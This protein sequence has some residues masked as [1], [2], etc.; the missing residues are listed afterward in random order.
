M[1][2]ATYSPTTSYFDCTYAPG[3]STEAADGQSDQV[4][5]QPTIYAPLGVPVTAVDQIVVPG[6]GTFEVDGTP[7]VWPAN[8]FSN[9]TPPRPVVIRLKAVAGAA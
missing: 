9:R 2:V 1:G 8:P 7:E 3:A 4:V 6:V 5:T